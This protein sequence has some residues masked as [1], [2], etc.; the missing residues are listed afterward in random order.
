M[1]GRY[2]GQPMA[3]HLP[4]PIEDRHFARWLALFNETA[5]EVCPPAAAAHFGDRARRVAASLAAGIARRGA[6]AC[7]AAERRIA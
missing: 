3:A 1:S 7:A 2:H 6:D 4:L 5:Q